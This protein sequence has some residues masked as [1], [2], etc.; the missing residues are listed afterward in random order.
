[1][2]RLSNS[3]YENFILCV[4]SITTTRRVLFAD[5]K[6]KKDVKEKSSTL[7]FIRFIFI[8][9][10]MQ[11]HSYHHITYHVNLLRMYY[12]VYL[13]AKRSIFLKK[14]KEWSNIQLQ[15]MFYFNR[16]MLDNVITVIFFFYVVI[17]KNKSLVND[18]SKVVPEPDNIFCCWYR[19]K[20]SDSK[21]SYTYLC[22][23]VINLHHYLHNDTL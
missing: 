15:F 22:M 13:Q 6:H 11:K 10:N 16:K 17:H 14:W 4:I 12:N 5:E 1:M 2:E 21:T 23:C 18:V 20:D 19:K 8:K 9:F 3:Y 7:T